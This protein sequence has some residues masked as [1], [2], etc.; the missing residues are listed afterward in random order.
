[1]VQ[2]FDWIRD[3][4]NDIELKRQILECM[5]GDNKELRLYDKYV[6][7]FHN[8]ETFL[9]VDRISDEFVKVVKV[10]IPYDVLKKMMD[11]NWEDC[12]G[13]QYLERV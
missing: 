12:T 1:M 8:D 11:G 4:V 3:A 10:R 2:S 6:I 13:I 5:K 7:M 9:T